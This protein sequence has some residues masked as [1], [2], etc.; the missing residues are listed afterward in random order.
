LAG[1]AK[2]TLENKQTLGAEEMAQRLRAL[3]SLP[4]GRGFNSQHP[5]G[6]SQLSVSSAPGDLTPPPPPHTHLQVGRTPIHKIK[7]NKSFKNN[8]LNY[9]VLIYFV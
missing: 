9:T 2:L 3:A 4:N 5:H 7:P 8:L 6:S 1:P